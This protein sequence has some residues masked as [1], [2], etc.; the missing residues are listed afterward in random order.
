MSR[1]IRRLLFVSDGPLFGGAERYVL[2]MATAAR[3]RG[4]QPHILWLPGPDAEA[5]VFDAARESHLALSAV[6]Y[7]GSVARLIQAFNACLAQSRPDAAIINASGRRRFWMTCW[8]ARRAGVPAAWVHHMVDQH[9]PRRDT[10]RWLGG[11]M[12]GPHWWRVPQALRHRLAAAAATAVVTSNHEDRDRIARRQA[13]RRPA[14]SVISPGID[15]H[16]FRFDAQA[17][18]WVHKAWGL[19]EPASLPFIVGTAARLVRGKGIEPLVEA[20]ALLRA[21]GLPILAVIA[22]EGPDREVFER[23]AGDLGVGDAVR[24][25]GFVREMPAFHSALD[26]FCLCSRTESFGL[27]LTEAMAC[28]RPVVATPTAGARRQI[29]H[30]ETGWQLRTFTAHELADALA[31]LHDGGERRQDLGRRGRLEVIEHF[32]IDLTL[33]RM[34]EAL[35]RRSRAALSPTPAPA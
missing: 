25:I 35:S 27:A 32:D 9:D 16:R 23:L 14:I 29:R 19:A 31:G 20:T 17:R 3:R 24:F 30:L 2:D 5:T 6:R 7:T 34:L 26:V 4:V 12:E 11:R 21:R 13:V 10:P 15:T 28:E 8:L 18:V 1:P 22:G 33:G